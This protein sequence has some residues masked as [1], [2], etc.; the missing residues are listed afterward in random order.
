ML[1]V[2]EEFCLLPFLAESVS[3]DRACTFLDRP[4]PRDDHE[5]TRTGC[6]SL[7]GQI[8][9]RKTCIELAPNPAYDRSP[10]RQLP[11]PKAPVEAI[12]SRYP[13]IIL[14]SARCAAM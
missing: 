7:A 13:L 6:L 11:R 1:I 10:A 3:V 2:S 12:V 4:K 5:P 14:L 9:F 8:P